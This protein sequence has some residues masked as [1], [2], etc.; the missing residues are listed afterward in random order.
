MWI[1]KTIWNDR[2]FTT[3]QFTSTME[4]QLK[5]FYNLDVFT[6]N[7]DVI[8]FSRYSF[9]SLETVLDLNLFFCGTWL[10]VDCRSLD[11]KSEGAD[12]SEEQSSSRRAE[13][14]RLHQQQQG[15]SLMTSWEDVSVTDDTN[16]DVSSA[17]DLPDDLSSC[18]D[19]GGESTG[20]ANAL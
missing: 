9:M 8:S 3:N 15:T 10:V 6:N 12:D 20:K 13:T 16:R 1:L 5:L 4:C 2:L 18:H 11:S 19:Q 17:S 14:E 7:Y